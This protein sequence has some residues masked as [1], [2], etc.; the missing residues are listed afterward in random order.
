MR[1]ALEIFWARELAATFERIDI[2]AVRQLVGALRT[3]TG[4]D[5]GLAAIVVG[6]VLHVVAMRW[7]A[8][9][10]SALGLAFVAYGAAVAAGGRDAARAMA[11]PFA[12]LVL[13][14]PLPMIERLAPPLASGGRWHWNWRRRARLWSRPIGQPG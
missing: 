7:A 5:A 14:I 13:A 3:G 2:G 9:P 11:Y 12:L 1:H 10:I 4:S 8:Y 6:L